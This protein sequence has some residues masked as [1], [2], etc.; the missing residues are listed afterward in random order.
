M[1]KVHLI[2]RRFENP[3]RFV[4]YCGRFT[5]PNGNKYKVS[6]RNLT[7]DVEY[8]S[9]KRCVLKLAQIKNKMVKQIIWRKNVNK[10][11]TTK[12]T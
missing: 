6:T 4:S 5:R 9:C 10:R 2:S 1:G 3:T 11:K 12:R 7:Y 8:T